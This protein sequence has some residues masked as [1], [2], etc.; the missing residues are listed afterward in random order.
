MS[1]PSFLGGGVHG[2]AVRLFTCSPL[3]CCSQNDPIS[4]RSCR[5]TT[6][7]PV[8]LNSLSSSMTASQT[9]ADQ[10]GVKLQKPTSKS[11]CNSSLRSQHQ[12]L[13]PPAPL[14]TRK[15]TS[16]SSSASSALR[17]LP[18]ACHQMFPSSWIS[19]VP[20]YTSFR[21]SRGLAW[22]RRSDDGCAALA[23]VGTHL[24][25][26]C[27]CTSWIGCSV[28]STTAASQRSARRICAY[29]LWDWGWG[30]GL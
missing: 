19:H 10:A 9:S 16:H 11:N 24:C 5:D 6:C 18:I 20:G 30:R 23:R 28:D 27:S 15:P 4:L 25:G 1:W 8:R 7:N 29:L 21:I 22:R 17:D 2:C 3:R 12:Q 26:F 13:A 14:S